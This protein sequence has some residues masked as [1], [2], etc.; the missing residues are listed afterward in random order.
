MKNMEKLHTE[1]LHMFLKNARIIYH[2]LTIRE[3]QNEYFTYCISRRLQKKR[4]LI[5]GIR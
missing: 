5:G 1:T 2:F 3:T 4:D